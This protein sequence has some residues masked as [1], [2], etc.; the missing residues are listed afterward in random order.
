VRSYLISLAAYLAKRF[1]RS[2]WHLIVSSRPAAKSPNISELLSTAIITAEDRRFYRHLGCDPW[3]MSRALLR[4]AIHKKVSGA[5]TI[6][7]QLV[8]T[9]RRRYERTLQ[10]KI[11]EI[12]L[13]ISLQSLA[14]KP[15]IIDWYLQVAYFGWQMN[16]V[17]HAAERLNLNLEKLTPFDAAYLASL[18]KYPLP[19]EPSSHRGQL[20]EERQAYILRHMRRNQP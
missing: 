7:Q 14:T 11:S 17:K 4:Y 13:A 5:S 6:D 12:I 1:L 15:Q 18:L 8:R 20:I 9:I 16:G 3:A 19:L 2:E 10:R